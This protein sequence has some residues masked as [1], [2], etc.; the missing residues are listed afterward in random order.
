MEGENHA[1]FAWRFVNTYSNASSAFILQRYNTYY[2]TWSPA[3]LV[4]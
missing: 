1:Y 4:K 3:A 2:T